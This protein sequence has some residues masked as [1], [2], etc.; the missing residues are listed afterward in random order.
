M[1]EQPWSKTVK[2]IILA[3]QP[4]ADHFGRT[5]LAKHPS[6]ANHPID[7]PDQL[8]RTFISESTH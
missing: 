4:W 5:T 2:L 8:V 6:W 7:H 1:V 3:K